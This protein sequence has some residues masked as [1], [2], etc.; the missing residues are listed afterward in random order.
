[1]ARS[2][3]RAVASSRTL[4]AA[5]NMS[6]RRAMG[7]AAAGGDEWPAMASDPMP[8]TSDFVIVGGGIIG[9]AMARE[10]A[11]RHPDSSIVLMEKESGVGQHASGR[12]SGVLHAGFY[13]SPESF[14]AKLTRA[15]N[16]FL[17]EYIEEKKI[18][19]NKCGKLVVARNESEVA[20]IDELLRRGTA[21][22]VPLE[23]ITAK[24][25]TEL[26]VRVRFDE[27]SPSIR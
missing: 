7:G 9:I 21:N 22:G 19:I 24:E 23:K 18:P 2:L 25:A 10:L 1:M 8:A 3:G 11:I 17:H 16:L 26:E 5:W 12:N 27:E 15:G 6:S 20:G 14:K 13:Y 4:A